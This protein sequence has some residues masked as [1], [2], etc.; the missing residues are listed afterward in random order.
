MLS[1]EFIKNGESFW[2]YLTYFRSAHPQYPSE[3]SHKPRSNRLRPQK[4]LSHG[5]GPDEDP[6][7]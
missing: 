2:E 1:S 5:M 6:I 3:T 7:I 4:W